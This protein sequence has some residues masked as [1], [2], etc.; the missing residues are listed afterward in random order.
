MQ[1]ASSNGESSLDATR[2]SGL[3]NCS[4]NLG[5]AGYAS[6]TRD[7]PKVRPKACRAEQQHR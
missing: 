2:G 7:L 3:A 4:G 6:L 1:P 5:L